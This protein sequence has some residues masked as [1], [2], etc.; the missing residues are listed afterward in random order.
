M[1]SLYKVICLLRLKYLLELAVATEKA[2]VQR[3][4]QNTLAPPPPQP[5][6]F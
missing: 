4:S 5:I 6:V 2:V 1:C 3:L